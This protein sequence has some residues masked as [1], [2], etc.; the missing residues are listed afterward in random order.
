[1]NRRDRRMRYFGFI[2]F[3]LSTKTIRAPSPLRERVGVR[4]KGV[5]DS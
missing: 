5:F 2:E 4:V 3:Q 1:M